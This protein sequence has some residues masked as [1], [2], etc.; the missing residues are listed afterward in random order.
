MFESFFGSKKKEITRTD[1]VWKNEYAKYKGILKFI[2]KTKSIIFVYYFNETKKQITQLIE[3]MQLEFSSDIHV[4]KK[5]TI[6]LAENLL[7]AKIDVTNS[8]FYFI[9]H[10]PSFA[11]EQKILNYLAN[12]LKVAEVIFH[13]SLQEPLL[14]YFGSDKIV[15]MLERIGFDENEPLQHAMISRSI[16]NAQQ[17]VDEKNPNAIETDTAA[18]WFE[19]NLSK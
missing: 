1:F 10:H 13:I 6:T 12:D 15:P 8:V 3:T 5:I 17:K 18:N 4:Q 11:T 19:I 16:V 14:H 9:E 7:D 2:D